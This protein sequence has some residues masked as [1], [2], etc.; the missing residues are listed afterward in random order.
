MK[1][2]KEKLQKIIQEELATMQQ[3]GEVDEALGT[4]LKSFGAG[5][6]DVAKAAASGIGG[7]ISAAKEA[8]D[9]ADQEIKKAKEEAKLAAEKVKTEADVN[10]VLQTVHNQVEAA[11]QSL[12]ALKM[13]MNVLKMNVAE[14][15]LDVPMILQQLRTASSALFHGGKK[16]K[17]LPKGQG[18]SGF[19]TT[20]ATQG[21]VRGARTV[22]QEQ[23]EE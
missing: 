18:V 1:V 20:K 13:K 23:E 12:D 10:K 3:E 7:A 5:V 14:G 4:F 15:G 16:S 2:T 6:G 11:I 9:K 21:P 19:D 22:R 8:S 17:P